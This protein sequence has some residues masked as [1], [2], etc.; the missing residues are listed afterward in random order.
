MREIEVE[1]A[2]QLEMSQ[3]IQR[4]YRSNRAH[5]R[6]RQQQ[7]RLEARDAAYMAELAVHQ[8]EVKAKRKRA[9]VLASVGLTEDGRGSASET[10][11]G[12]GS[13]SE[14]MGSTSRSAAPG[15]YP[16]QTLST[17]AASPNNTRL[18]PM[19]ITPRLTARPKKATGDDNLLP[20]HLR[21]PGEFGLPSRSMTEALAPLLPHLHRRHLLELRS[22][23]EPTPTVR[24]VLE[25]ANALLGG[26]PDWTLAKL[27]LA[28]PGAFLMRLRTYGAAPSFSPD[29][30]A[31][32]IGTAYVEA[33]DFTPEAV[34]LIGAPAAAALCEWC[35]IVVYTS[36][37]TQQRLATW[38]PPAPVPSPRASPRRLPS[39]P[40]PLAPR[41]ESPPRFV[42]SPR[43]VGTA[44]D[45]P[46]AM[47]PEWTIDD[48]TEPS[49]SAEPTPAREPRPPTDK[50][51]RTP[52]APRRQSD[53]TTTTRSHSLPSSPRALSL[54]PLPPPK[55]HV[56]HPS[57]LPPRP[58]PSRTARKL[59]RLATKLGVHL[60]P[61]QPADTLEESSSGSAVLSSSARSRAM[62]TGTGAHATGAESD[63][64]LAETLREVLHQLEV[65]AKAAQADAAAATAATAAGGVGQEEEELPHVDGRSFKH[66][67]EL[68]TRPASDPIKVTLQLRTSD[69]LVPQELVYTLGHT[70][71]EQGNGQ[72]MT[73]SAGG[74]CR[75]T[76]GT[77]TGTTAAAEAAAEAVASLALVRRVAASPPR[78]EEKR[79]PTL[80]HEVFRLQ[81]GLASDGV[82]TD[83][84]VLAT[85]KLASLWMDGGMRAARAKLDRASLARWRAQHAAYARGHGLRR[86][87]VGALREAQAQ[88]ERR[89]ERE[90]NEKAHRMRLWKLEDEAAFAIQG[91]WRGLITRRDE[92]VQ[93]KVLKTVVL[94]RQRVARSMDASHQI[95]EKER[96]ARQ[97]RLRRTRARSS[98]R[99]ANSPEGRE[100]AARE[101]EAEALQAERVAQAKLDAQFEWTRGK[102]LEEVG[103]AL[104]TGL[105]ALIESLN[106]H[107]GQ[108]GAP[109]PSATASTD[110]AKT[111]VASSSS[112]QPRDAA[113][114]ASRRLPPSRYPSRVSPS[115]L[116]GTA[117]SNRRVKH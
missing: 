41:P 27:E 66:G 112:T 75:A 111:S 37:A 63:E 6:K 64:T 69:G 70:L 45:P 102:G 92:A 30:R 58:Q 96:V 48:V 73:S 31:L 98:A 59:L 16:R 20:E 77:G 55:P 72:M 11:D 81:R 18:P 8:R 56:P 51:A 10:E 91:A 32:A 94:L 79:Q 12:R 101:A 15:W 93:N 43:A 5:M 38:Q 9:R 103:Q 107:G 7:Q 106:M 84:V 34:A 47:V 1:A 40:P 74:D 99:L 68:Q 113:S 21:L 95:S 42:E 62:G 85:R 67:Q 46:K 57:A 3:R 49:K 117:A 22:Y 115:L 108:F 116:Q 17:P 25:C 39:L 104:G 83:S 28:D 97:A 23:L 19:T 65:A 13:A 87:L 114:P 54:A 4:Q 35:R 44:D 14:G 110:D 26:A 33:E 76:T 53:R 89:A 82:P 36:W 88:R 52:A 78:L 86:E 71:K 80:R 29:R 61:S 90:A 105:G 24:R 100:K 60:D 109:A 2:K 50:S